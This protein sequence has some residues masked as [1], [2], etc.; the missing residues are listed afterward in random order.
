M[1]YLL[2]LSSLVTT[3][4]SSAQLPNPSS[5]TIKRL[6][7]F[8]SQY[9]TARN[10]DVWLPADYTPTKKYAVLYMHD[11]QMLYD[12]SITWNK[13]EWGVDETMSALLKQKKIQPCIVVGIWNSGAGR[14][15][16]YFPQQPFESLS[17]FQQDS[18]YNDKGT[19]G[20]S[21]FNGQ[22]IQSDNYLKFL[23]NEL[24]PFIDSTY[25]TYKDRQ[26]TF[27]AGSS[28]GGLISLYAICKYPQVFGAAA[29]LSTHWPGLF[30][31]ENNPI[32]QA[33]FNYMNTHLPNPATHRLYFD[34]GDQTVDALYPP[35]Q[36]QADK[37]VKAK[38]F[39]KKNWTTRFFPGENHSET[40]W[41]KRLQVPLE[42]LLRK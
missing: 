42:F 5:G 3:L 1:K 29:C 39:T 24:K 31:L 18:I 16:D 34:Y 13:Q 22:K 28:M 20:Y 33:F 32:P 41:K 23:V 12:S 30:T 26:H 8:A 25:S 14:F 36:Q 9:V 35:L 19:N 21:L 7:N 11:G 6:E 4:L 37:I 10:V 40:A 15:T 2:F 27:I 38:G 17:L